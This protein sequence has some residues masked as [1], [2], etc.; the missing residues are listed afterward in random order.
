MNI[1]GVLFLFLLVGGMTVIFQEEI[2]LLE[3]RARSVS[4]APFSNRPQN[5]ETDLFIDPNFI[6]KGID[7]NPSSVNRRPSSET[8]INTN[9]VS[10]GTRGG[11]IRTGD[12]GSRTEII[13]G[14]TTHTIERDV[15]D[16]RAKGFIT[17]ITRQYQT[18]PFAGSVIFVDH[19]TALGN[20]NANRE[21]F[22]LR[23][24]DI[25]PAPINIS[26][27]S[28]FDYSG[29]KSYT[30]PDGAEILNQNNSITSDVQLQRGD[31]AIIVSGRSPNGIS[32]RV[33]KC[34][35]FQNQ[36]KSFYPSIKTG[37]VDPLD[38]FNAFGKVP[39]SDD[40]CYRTVNRLNSCKVVT[41][42]PSGI[43]RECRDLLEN[44]LT[45]A[46]CIK[47]HKNDADFFKAEWRIFLGQ[48]KS[49]WSNKNNALYLVD[50][51]NRLVASFIF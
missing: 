48:N 5:V 45:Y 49:L 8:P 10:V 33:N 21:Y 13:L 37:C 36:F 4:R 19:S 41:S 7:K 34:T 12:D 31:T 18:S 50:E 28:V 16:F 42:I 22:I 15:P 46:G 1:F 11:R 29:R 47:N 40:I 6:T 3:S 26:N 25:L 14:Q 32:F 9:R 43:S 30:F 20:S 38:E 24:S 27:W 23:A 44:E 51:N 17:S 2:R 35:G 39:F